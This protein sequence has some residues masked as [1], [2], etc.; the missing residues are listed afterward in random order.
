M[1][2]LD[3][4][5]TSLIKPPSVI[6]E[7]ANCLK[8]YSANPGRGGHKLSLFAESKVYN[9]R[10]KLAALLNTEDTQNI[11]F[12][13]NTTEGLNMII[14]G[15]LREGD[16]AIITS[17]EHNSVL[18]PLHKLTKAGVSY[19]V[20]WADENGVINPEGLKE[21]IVPATTL[22]ICNH[23]SNVCGNIAPVKRL[24]EIS[25]EKGC[26]FLLDGAQSIGSIDIN[27]KELPIDFIAFPGHK[28]LLGPQG[29]GAVYIKSSQLLDTILEGGTG[30]Q[31]E[32]L[33]QP[34]YSPERYESGTLNTPGIVGL[35]EGVS[36]ILSHKKELFQKEEYL[37]NYFMN[38]LLN[39]KGITLYGDRNIYNRTGVFAL[40]FDNIDSITA[41][42]TLSES[43]NIATRGGLHCSP[44][45]H[46]TLNTIEKGALRISI[47]AFT[48]KKDLDA[49]L[50]A[51]NKMT[52][53]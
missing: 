45:A 11:I 49:A 14:K 8:Y 46:R 9:C 10:E 5:A 34:D 47:G 7:S 50:F 21:L 53:K 3:N 4:A 52:K 44:L 51:I 36:Y 31:S 32:S 22:I 28:G 38:R 18:R 29:T 12:T 20:L 13:K 25:H 16:H 35:S 19:S 40:N 33:E 26:K 17:M 39:I 6:K 24:M 37:K 23:V 30:S 1:I 15:F 43:F 41:S 42:Q 27:T 2:Y 48:T